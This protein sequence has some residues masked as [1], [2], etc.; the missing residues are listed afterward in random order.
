MQKKRY[1]LTIMWDPVS[2]EVTHLSE[3][4]SDLDNIVFEINGFRLKIPKELQK[5]MEDINIEILGLS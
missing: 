4:F 1:R 2:G 3:E 5:E